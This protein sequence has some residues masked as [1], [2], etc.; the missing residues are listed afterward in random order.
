[1]K[2]MRAALLLLAGVLTVG[3]VTVF[4]TQGDQDDPLVTLS[5]LQQVMTPKLEAQVDA[6]VEKNAQE[7]A[8]QLE[9]AVT[10]YETRVDER[11]A[12]AGTAT[13]Q[14]EELSRGKEFLPGAGRE[15]LVVSGSLN[16]VGKLMD[17][18]AGQ[19]VSAGNSLT[20]GHLYVTVDA[21]SGCKATTAATVMSR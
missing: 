19:E 12:A 17:T 4:A 10:S 3:A 20:A 7:L 1:M 6:A 11:L 13:F 14:S 8:K 16:A 18:T 2:R 5:Y 21:T 9:I 15:L